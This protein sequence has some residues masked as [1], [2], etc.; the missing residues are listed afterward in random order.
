MGSMHVPS[1]NNAGVYLTSKKI[2]NIFLLHHRLPLAYIRQME[3]DLLP[4]SYSV[5]EELHLHSRPHTINMHAALALAADVH[6]ICVYIAERKKK[7]M[8]FPGIEPVTS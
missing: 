7:S 2:S 4:T 3:S 8:S 6:A 1:C 5:S